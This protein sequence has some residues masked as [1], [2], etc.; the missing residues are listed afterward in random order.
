MRNTK[1]FSLYLIF[2]L[3]S[4]ALTTSVVDYVFFSNNKT[5]SIVKP[6][7]EELEA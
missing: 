4:L 5:D 7:A 3:L 2:W 6:N 1:Q